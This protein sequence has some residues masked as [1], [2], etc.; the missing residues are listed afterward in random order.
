MTKSIGS[1]GTLFLLTALTIGAIQTKSQAY[2][3]KHGE[4]LVVFVGIQKTERV[5]VSI[6]ANGQSYSVTG[7]LDKMGVIFKSLGGKFQ[8]AQREVN[9][10]P[11]H[12]ILLEPVE[13]TI[14][15]DN[16]QLKKIRA[17]RVEIQYEKIG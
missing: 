7:R 3:P 17:N 2:E 10:R 12:F 11:N 5:K 8:P 1:T 4:W 14:R 9:G 13:V 15:R 6:Q 16:K